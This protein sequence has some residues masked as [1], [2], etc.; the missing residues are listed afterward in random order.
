M[1][2]PSSMSGAATIQTQ[3]LT[4]S[5]PGGSQHRVRWQWRCQVDGQGVEVFPLL[6]RTWRESVIEKLSSYRSLP[7][8]WNSYG[9]PPPSTLAIQKAIGFVSVLLDDSQPRPRVTPVSGGGIQF[10]WSFGKRELE[11]EFLPN[12]TIKYIFS[13][14]WDSDGIEDTIDSV[15]ISEVARLFEWLT[16]V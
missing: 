7:H 6:A 1:N 12:G 8:N 15:T 4:T 3:L 2:I 16:T 11:I 10:D 13:P 5:W 14:D 9:S